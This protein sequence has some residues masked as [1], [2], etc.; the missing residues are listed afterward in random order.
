[1]KD[2]NMLTDETQVG[3][4]YEHFQANEETVTRHELQLRGIVSRQREERCNK[5]YVTM[6]LRTAFW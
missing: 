2:A 1:M 6:T 4:E 3:C 5:H